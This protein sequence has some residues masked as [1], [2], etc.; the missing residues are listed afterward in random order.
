MRWILVVWLSMSVWPARAAEEGD[1]VHAIDPVVQYA[2]IPRVFLGPK[3][4]SDYPGWLA[5]MNKARKKDRAR[6]AAKLKKDPLTFES[7]YDVYTEKD[8]DQLLLPQTKIMVHD[9]CLY[10]PEQ[11]KYTVSKCLDDYERRWGGV[12]RVLL[13]PAYPNIGTDNRNQFDM[14]RDLP[15]G[16]AG[17]KGAVSDFHRRGVKVCLPFN[18]WDEG[19]RP[20]KDEPDEALAKIVTEVDADCVFA[21]T[22]V[23]PERDFYEKALAKGKVV[24]FEPELGYIYIDGLE[25][26]PKPEKT[27]M[28]EAV[29]WSPMSWGYEADENARYPFVPGVDRYKWMESR[30]TPCVTLRQE[31]NHIDSLHFAFFNGLCFNA[32]ENIFGDWNAMTERDSEILRRIA[33]V[34]RAVPRYFRSPDW[35]PHAPTL[36]EGV[37]ASRFPLANGTVWAL[38]NRSTNREATGAQLRVPFAGQRFFDL[39]HGKEIWA[40]VRGGQAELSFAIEEGGFGALFELPKGAELDPRVPPLLAEMKRL[41]ERKLSSFSAEWQ[42]MPQRMVEI[43]PT[44]RR[45]RGEVPAGMVP[46]VP[47]APY[48]YKSLGMVIEQYNEPGVQFPW[49]SAPMI[50]HQRV[51]TLK[52][53]LI[54]K[55]LVTNA[56]FQRFLDQ[57]HYAPKGWDAHNFLKHWDGARVP[58]GLEKRPV[59]WV[60]LEDSRAYCAWAGKRLPNDWEWQYAAQGG[61]S[62]EFPWGNEWRADLAPAGDLTRAP[63]LP[64]PVGMYPA[65]ASPFGVEELTGH[66]W[67]WTNEF[68]DRGNRRALLR[69]GTYFSAQGSMW[70]FPQSLRRDPEGQGYTPNRVNE[71]GNYLLMAPSLDRAGTIG[72]RCAADLKD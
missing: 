8:L 33:T 35:Q 15:G 62:R 3:Q 21:D 60:S 26:H 49:E 40:A 11:R 61:D 22:M 51:M 2:N 69:G 56:D 7:I 29:H 5:G 59:V 20:E 1:A 18:P 19:T 31:R 41:A 48:E 34:Y 14:L 10:D 70:Y 37:F 54:D 28:L 53:F 23:G 42:P 67:Q 52:P 24:A 46:V 44:R 72:F 55:H 68:R 13:W 64:D 36:Q 17:L 65:G 27:E 71:Q 57:D 43:A 38:V 4:K 30:H 63:R 45:A 58:G 9:R 39:W 6:I 12:G 47:K 50:N 66:V 32:W 16:L 25:R